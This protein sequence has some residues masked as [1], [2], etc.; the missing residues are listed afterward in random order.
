MPQFYH[1]YFYC[2]ALFLM[3]DKVANF[4]YNKRVI[5]DS[6]ASMRRIKHRLNPS[7]VLISILYGSYSSVHNEEGDVRIE[8]GP[9][10]RL[11][12]VPNS[13]L[14]EYLAWLASWDY[15]SNLETN[16]KY[17]TFTVSRPNLW[18]NN[19]G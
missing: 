9:F 10:A 14:K 19:N 1:I 3:V 8:I 7:K 13:R 5:K 2:Q 18:K 6:K 12:R 4:E 17:A 16:K 11:I 15:I